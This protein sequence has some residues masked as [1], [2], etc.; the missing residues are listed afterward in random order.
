LVIAALLTKRLI[1]RP[2][3]N[4]IIRRLEPSGARGV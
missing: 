4:W 3:R 2:G 1:E